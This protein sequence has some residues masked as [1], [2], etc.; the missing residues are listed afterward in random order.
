VLSRTRLMQ[1]ISH[2][3]WNA[4]DRTVDVLVGRLR[5]KLANHATPPGT[6]TTV[7][8]EGY[9]FVHARK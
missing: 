4:D 8:G 1:A 6:I 5:R 3:E 2:R 7:H 9:M